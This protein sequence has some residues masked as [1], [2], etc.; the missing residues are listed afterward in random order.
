MR[1]AFATH[2]RARRAGARA[3]KHS[4]MHPCVDAFVRAFGSRRATPRR[5]ERRARRPGGGSATSGAIASPRFPATRHNEASLSSPAPHRREPTRPAHRMGRT[6]APRGRSIHRVRRGAPSR[7]LPFNRSV[8]LVSTDRTL[9]TRLPRY[10]RRSSR[11]LGAV[12]Q[13]QRQAGRLPARRPRQ[14]LQRRSPSP[15]RSRA[16]QRAAVRPARLRPLDAAR[17][18]RE[19]HDMASRRR[20]RAAARDARRR[21]L[22]RVRR[23]V[24]QRARARICANAPGA[25]GRARRARHL[26]GAPV[27]AALVLPGRRV[28]AVSGSV[29]RLHRAHSARRAR[30]SD[31]R[32]WKTGSCCAMR[33]VSRTSR[34]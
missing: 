23:L 9:C 19:Q 22:A 12:R 15:L 28:V 30:G 33:I 18:P 10:R 31:R 1:A 4:C 8:S 11:V 7:L 27:R 26:H 14:R 34:A 21:A 6:H 25:R 3:R 29:G 2:A 5:D 32:V 20:H 17:E 16:L 13:P 24:G